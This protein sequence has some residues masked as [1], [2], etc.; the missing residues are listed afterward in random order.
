MKF[1]RA[2]GLGV[3]FLVL[4][5]SMPRVFREL[6]ETIL[7]MLDTFQT[8]LE[9]AESFTASPAPLVPRIR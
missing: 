1:W 7:V 9:T 6:E 3:L 8:V 4:A 2:I 5:I